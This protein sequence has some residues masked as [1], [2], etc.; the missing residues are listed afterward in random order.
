MSEPLGLHHQYV[1]F[2][3]KKSVL[4]EWALSMEGLRRGANFAFAGI[5]TFPLVLYGPAADRASCGQ[6][7]HGRPPTRSSFNN[8]ERHMMAFRPVSEAAH[9][10][11]YDNGICHISI[12]CLSVLSGLL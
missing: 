1:L 7:M 2:V 5:C 6:M 4:G 11:S 12:L 8:D 3:I 10:W 9:S